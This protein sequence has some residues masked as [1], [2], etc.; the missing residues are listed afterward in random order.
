MSHIHNFRGEK[1]NISRYLKPKKL[2]SVCKI[3]K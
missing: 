3:E 2:N 1:E